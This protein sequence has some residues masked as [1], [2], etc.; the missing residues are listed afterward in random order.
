VRDADV[1]AVLRVRLD[2]QHADDDSLV[3]EELGL[4][5]GEARIDLCVVNGALNGYEIKSESDTLLRLPTQ[6]QVYSRVLDYVTIISGSRHLNSIAARVPEWWGLEEACLIDEEVI[7]EEL[8]PALPNP[9]VDSLAVAQLLWRDEVLAELESRGL[10]RGVRTKPR[11][12]L[13]QRLADALLP[14][15]LGDVVRSRLKSRQGWRES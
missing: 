9:A 11:K 14:G 4:C 1:R 12:V 5:E 3:L 13:W 6:Q 8:R 7:L 15:E 2:A 10:D